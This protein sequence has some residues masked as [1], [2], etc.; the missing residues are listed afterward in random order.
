MV[1]QIAMFNDIIKNR[2]VGVSHDILEKVIHD[3]K[4]KPVKISLQLNESTD[5]AQCSKS[6]YCYPVCQE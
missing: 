1:T 5:V 3:I 6:I 4:V 2:I